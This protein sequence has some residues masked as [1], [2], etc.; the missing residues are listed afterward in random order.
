MASHLIKVSYLNLQYRRWMLAARYV[1]PK[2]D[3]FALYIGNIAFSFVAFDIVLPNFAVSVLEYKLRLQDYKVEICYSELVADLHIVVIWYVPRYNLTV[4]VHAIKHIDTAAV[5][6]FGAK[7]H[8]LI[9]VFPL[10]G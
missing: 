7:T 2:L 9:Y 8:N 4:L 10:F 1:A 6:H 5:L 3:R